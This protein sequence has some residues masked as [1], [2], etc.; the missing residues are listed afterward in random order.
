MDRQFAYEF[1]GFGA[2]DLQF[3]FEF[4]GFGAM[5][6]PDFPA[7]AGQPA[8]TFLYMQACPSLPC[9]GRAARTYVS[10]HAGVSIRNQDGP[11]MSQG[12]PKMSSKICSSRDSRGNREKPRTLR[13]PRAAAEAVKGEE[14]VRAAEVS[15]R[16]GSS[17]RRN[18][19][20]SRGVSRRP[21]TSQRLVAC[22]SLLE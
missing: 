4:I 16:R 3:P 20:A 8:R 6:A 1:A 11:K 14:A 9:R 12:G 7:G 17:Q 21:A 10:V 19:S 13:K 2:M 15:Q 22:L 18:F 5:D